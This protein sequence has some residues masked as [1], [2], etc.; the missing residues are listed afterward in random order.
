M[1]ILHSHNA[2]SLC[3][4]VAAYQYCSGA[5]AGEQEARE[6]IVVTGLSWPAAGTCSAARLLAIA[7]SSRRPVIYLVEESSKG[8]KKKRKKHQTAASEGSQQLEPT[9]K[10]QR[11]RQSGE[12]IVTFDTRRSGRSKSAFLRWAA[13]SRYDYVWHIEEDVLYTGKWYS[14]LALAEPDRDADLIAVFE[15]WEKNALKKSARVR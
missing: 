13:A 7:E 3:V 10:L 12:S 4:F 5:I 15:T 8:K 9:Q 11:Q 1:S 14:A 2:F 6:A